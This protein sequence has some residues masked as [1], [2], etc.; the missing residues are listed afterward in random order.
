[1]VT[2][3]FADF[4]TTFQTCEANL[5]K[6]RIY[7][8]TMFPLKVV[9]NFFLACCS[10]FQKLIKD[11]DTILPQEV[12]QGYRLILTNIVSVIKYDVFVFLLKILDFFQ[13]IFLVLLYL[14]A[15]PRTK[16]ESMVA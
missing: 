9:R 8:H 6:L 16:T 14:S 12:E 1:M 4:V 11:T 3:F 2:S 5:L 7:M 15:G 13:K 10:Y